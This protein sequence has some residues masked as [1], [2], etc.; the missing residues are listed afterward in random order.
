MLFV[1]ADNDEQLLCCIETLLKTSVSYGG[2][3]LQDSRLNIAL[4]SKVL[5]LL[6][7]YRPRCHR[8]TLAH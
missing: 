4:C 3:A 5:R 6:T 7:I 8:H 1:C 2:M